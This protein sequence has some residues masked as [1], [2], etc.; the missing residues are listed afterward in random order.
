MIT[1]EKLYYIFMLILISRLK[2][3]HSHIQNDEGIIDGCELYALI[4]DVL[5]ANGHVSVFILFTL[6]HLKGF[7][8]LKFKCLLVELV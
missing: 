7:L 2:I 1:Q 6:F 8:F 4:R 3:I 5:E